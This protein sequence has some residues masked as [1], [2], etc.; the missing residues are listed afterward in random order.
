MTLTVDN[1]APAFHVRDIRG[2]MVGLE[3]FQGKKLLVS[4][5]RYASCPFCN[6]RIHTLNQKAEE[7][8]QQ[9]MEMIAVFQSTAQQI[10]KYAG[11]EVR[12]F[13][14]IADDKRELYRLYG[15]QTS[16]WGFSKAFITRLPDLL[17]T[18]LLGNLPGRMD[19]ELNR[20]PADFL[21][22]EAGCVKL[23]YYGSDIGDHLPL[24][25]LEQY[26]VEKK[27]ADVAYNAGGCIEKQS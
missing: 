26:L 18:S 6:L 8:R 7:Y 17:R 13:T 19:N 25:D 24:A 5:Y 2:E 1:K 9:G 21:I 16:W 23:A 14:I 3:Q 22:D 15:V 27:S 10:N 11:K 20:M 4:F 12:P